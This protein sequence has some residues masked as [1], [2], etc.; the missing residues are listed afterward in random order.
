[1]YPVEH[2]HAPKYSSWALNSLAVRASYGVPLIH[3]VLRADMQ[4]AS[5]PWLTHVYIVMN[6]NSIVA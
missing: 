1:M 5:L 4:M 3:S 2:I 6:F